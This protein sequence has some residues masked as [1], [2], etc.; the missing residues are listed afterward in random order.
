M[1]L[2][3][4][5]LIKCGLILALLWLTWK[6]IEKANMKGVL[7]FTILT[8]V[9]AVYS[10]V[11]LTTT[12]YQHI[13]NTFKKEPEPLPERVTVEKE[14]FRDRV[15]KDLEEYQDRRDGGNNE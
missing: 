15:E 10:P 12:S 4:F 9:A 13:E 2:I 5:P 3:W 7:V 1:E 6:Q 11:K 14:S 8:V